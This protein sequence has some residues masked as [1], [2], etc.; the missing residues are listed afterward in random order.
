[1]RTNF[2]LLIFLSI[3]FCL[4]GFS[5]TQD[6]TMEAEIDTAT[7][8]SNQTCFNCHGDKTYYYYNDWVERDVKA[9]MNPYLI[10][11]SA[12]YYEG[13]HKTF[14]CIDCHSMD[15]ETFPHDG[16]LRME[17]IYTCIDC[18]GGD[19][20][21]ADYQFERIE[22]EF[23]QSVHSANH[24][25][26][27]TCW[28]CHD[29]HSYKVAARSEKE[30][31]EMVQYNN[32]MCLSCHAD[33]DNYQLISSLSNPNILETHTWL[34]NQALHFQKVRCIECHAN[35]QEDIYVAHNV[36]MKEDAV[37]KC[38][39]CH[40]ENS[41][42]M[43]SLYRFKAKEFRTQKGFLNSAVLGNSYIIGA[44]RNIY[45]NRISLLIYGLVLLGIAIHASLRI[46]I[47]K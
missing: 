40:S 28:S 31:T 30:I 42:L 20:D 17:E 19:D 24:T 21:Y 6:E 12:R 5:M 4:P 47:K 25:E 44:N 27:F 14:V 9:R 32:D 7:Y 11:D 18:H 39:E 36:G 13:V 2:S 29:P 26:N 43:A 35:I 3:L 41:L 37:K 15:Y 33:F 16:Q 38:E 10:I 45:L 1:M 22:E 46:I 8:S 34:P 23:L